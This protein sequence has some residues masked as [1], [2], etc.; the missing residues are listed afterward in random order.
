MLA[1]VA[2][3]P[4]MMVAI[5]NLKKCQIV[6]LSVVFYQMYM[7]LRVIK[8]VPIFLDMERELIVSLQSK[9]NPILPTSAEN[10]IL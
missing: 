4:R 6:T 5:C 3:E 10:G 8:N 7:I 1:E 2:I 9:A